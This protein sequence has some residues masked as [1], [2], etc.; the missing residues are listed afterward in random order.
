MSRAGE[1]G[2]IRLKSLLT[3]AVIAAVIYVSVKVVPVY[4]DS[5]EFHD[6]LK[7]EARFAAIQ[8]KSEEEVRD[9]VYKKAQDLGLPLRREDIKVRKSR[10]GFFIEVKYSVD[11]VLPGYT[12]TLDFS[13]S[14]N[15]GSI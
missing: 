9:N 6:A 10:D 11:V 3:L 14:A 2:A 4:I 13:P 12:L 15:P 8:R 5:Y 1:R 7:Q